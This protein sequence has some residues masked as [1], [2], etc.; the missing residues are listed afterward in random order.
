[1]VLLC[2]VL[3]STGHT[4]L[5]CSSYSYE[6]Y[7]NYFSDLQSTVATFEES[8]PVVVCGDFNVDITNPDHFTQKHQLLEHLAQQTGTL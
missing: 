2:E 5:P 1:M 4:D 3:L 8:G 7:A 6:V